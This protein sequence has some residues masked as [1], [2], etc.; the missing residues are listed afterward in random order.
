M[1]MKNWNW[2]DD[3]DD[4]DLPM[5]ISPIWTKIPKPEHNVVGLN[6]HIEGSEPPRPKGNLEK[7]GKIKL[8][9]YE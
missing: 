8:T 6:Y 1:M 9:F 2:N 7:E 5:D 4:R 3:V